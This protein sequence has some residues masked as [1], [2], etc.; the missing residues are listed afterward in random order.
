MNKLVVFSTIAACGALPYVAEAKPKSKPVNFVVI[1]CDDMGYGDLSCY[2]SPSIKTPNLDRMAIEG[3]KW[4]SFYS[5]A[6]VST[7]SRAA[8][9]TGRY[10][11]RNGQT[12]V[13][14][15]DS[16]GGLPQSEVTIA[17]LLKSRDYVTACV[18]KWHLGH[19]EEFLP[20]N[21]GFDYFYGI[22]YSNDMSRK[23]QDILGN[24]GYQYELPFF[25]QNEVIEYD[26]DQSLFTRR[27]TEYAVDFIEEHRREPFFLYLAHPQPHIPVYRSDGFQGRSAKGK[28]GD[29]IEELDWSVGEILAALMD[30][31][32]ADNTLVVFSSD[33]GPW[34][35]TEYESGSA[36][37]LRDGKKSAYEGGF[38]VPG[39]FWGAM[40]EPGYVTDMGATLD[41][42]PTMCELAGVELPGDRTLDGQS[43]VE[44]L[45]G[46]SDSPRDELVYYRTDEL[47]ALRKGDYKIIYATKPTY[48]KGER[49]KIVFDTPQLYN[50][51]VDAEE[52]YNIAADHPEIVK[53]LQAL[54]EKHRESIREF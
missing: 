12:N 22:P 33:N 39:I 16:H 47:Y 14:F 20:L 11:M 32:L 18:G 37:T 44:V 17:S 54:T 1:Y 21:H 36:G 50:V 25:N 53:E 34:L 41:L 38:R 9:L 3:Q 45:G 51:A 31:G 23:E 43:L 5:A 26:P 29:V 7:P 24:F 27:L 40:V 2:G 35:I 8:L 28:Y 13:Y 48:A 15:P 4:S 19:Q 52:R 30:N 42:L 49:V 46:R 10:P 6:S